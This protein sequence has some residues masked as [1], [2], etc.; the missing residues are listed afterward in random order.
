MR[1]G[2]ARVSTDGQDTALQVDALKAAG[3][4]RIY[5]D[6]GISGAVTKR[7]Q[8][9]GCLKALKSGDVLVVWKL[10]RLGRSLGHLI[11]TIDVL[12]A[13]GVGFKSLSEAIDTTTP[14]GTLVFHL[15]GALAQFERSLIAERTAAGRVAAKKRGVRFGRP[16]SLTDQQIAHARQQVE[17]GMPVPEVADL[18]GVGRAT[19]YRHLAGV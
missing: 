10:D 14:Q 7:P 2:Y 12:R 3:C 6:K 19:V 17:S 9:D 11:E 15:M 18:L 5:Q 13:R 4:G 16:R 1:I 8:L